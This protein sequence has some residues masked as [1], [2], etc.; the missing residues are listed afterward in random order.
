MRLAGFIVG[1]ERSGTT[2]TSAFLSQH[3]EV[4]V[5]NDPHYLNFFADAILGACSSGKDIEAFK[6]RLK[7]PDGTR[8]LG[9]FLNKTI[10]QVQQW[11]TRWD[12]FKGDPVDIELF[13]RVHEFIRDS[14]PL[15]IREYF[16]KFHLSLIPKEIRHKKPKYIVKIPDL[17]RY[18][19]IIDSL[20]QDLPVIYNLRHPVCNIASIIEPNRDRGW[21]FEKIL[22]WYRLFFPRDIVEKTRPRLVYTRYEDLVL[23]SRDRTVDSIL[24]ALKLDPNKQALK[25]EFFYPNQ[26]VMRK[27]QGRVDPKRLTSS[28]GELTPIQLLKALEQTTDIQ[29]SFY[30]DLSLMKLVSDTSIV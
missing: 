26:K 6:A 11:Y 21:D 28:L 7:L 25:D 24:N 18:S 29:T 3:P 27:T 20:Y 10:L 8:V 4:Y 14:H 12:E 23:Y 16:H 17:A 9:D 13:Y 22:S 15:T 5:I 30:P 19:F 1:P 2:L